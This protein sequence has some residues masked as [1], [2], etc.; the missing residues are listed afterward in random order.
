M[1]PFGD[2]VAK[3]DTGNALY[4]V[5]H[6]EDIEVK[7]NKITFTNGEKTITTK[8]VG[9]YV[10]TTGGGKDERYLIELEFEFAGSSYG[11]ITFGLDN[12]DAFNTDVLLNRKTMRMLNVMVNP[13]RKY[14]VT[15]QFTLDK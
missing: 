1:K 4:P 2:L 10:S 15:T 6:A 13:R 11:K 7:G 12:R 9:D 8:L 14:I 3:F 5:L